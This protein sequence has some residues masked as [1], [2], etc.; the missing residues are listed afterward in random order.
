MKIIDCPQLGLSNPDLLDQSTDTRTAHT[1]R[2]FRP[3]QNVSGSAICRC[4]TALRAVCRRTSE[5]K[6]MSVS[7]QWS[8]GELPLLNGLGSR[9][10][11]ASADCKEHD[12]RPDQQTQ[13]RPQHAVQKHTGIVG[14]LPKHI[15]WPAGE[16]R[17]GSSLINGNWLSSC[18]HIS[19]AL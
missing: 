10:Q 1:S 4:S 15:I 14:M 2:A 7:P 19:T 9:S 5:A 3:T 13:H 8:L 12:E 16:H 6:W 18:Y 17:E 11:T